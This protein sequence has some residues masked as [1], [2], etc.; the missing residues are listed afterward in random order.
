M[1][2]QYE[3]EQTVDPIPMQDLNM[4]HRKR[5]IRIGQKVIR[6]RKRSTGQTITREIKFVKIK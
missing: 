4:E 1:L 6:L 2:D 3:Q 5:K